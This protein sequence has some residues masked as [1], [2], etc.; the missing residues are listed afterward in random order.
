MKN[1]QQQIEGRARDNMQR[2]IEIVCEWQRSGSPLS[3]LPV[4]LHD[5]VHHQRQHQLNNSWLIGQIQGHHY[6]IADEAIHC[7]R[8]YY[9]GSLPYEELPAAVQDDIHDQSL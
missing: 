8:L 5:W 6:E 9:E 4:T 1:I 2:D 3:E 7:L